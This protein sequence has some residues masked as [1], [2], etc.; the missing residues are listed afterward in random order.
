L[1]SESLE[2][3]LRPPSLGSQGHPDRPNHRVGWALFKRLVLHHQ[4]SFR[5]TIKNRIMSVNL[6]LATLMRVIEDAQDKMPEGEYLAAMNALGAL[7]R[8]VP[9]PAAAAAPVHSR[10]PPTIP[11]ND[12][13]KNHQD[14]VDVVVTT[15]NPTTNLTT[16]LSGRALFQSHRFSLTTATTATTTTTP[17]AVTTEYVEPAVVEHRGPGTY[18]ISGWGLIL[19]FI[20]VTIVLY[21]ELT[22]ISLR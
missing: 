4:S 5:A 9:A 3:R 15:P 18:E 16:P 19:R 11:G 17:V 1:H 7:H 12:C 21:L 13:E 20:V 22:R 14:A 6:N 8:V 2:V 10:G